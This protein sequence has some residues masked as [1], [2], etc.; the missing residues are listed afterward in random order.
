[1]RAK[2]AEAGRKG[3]RAGTRAKRQLAGMISWGTRTD[4]Q[5]LEIIRRLA[6][7]GAAGGRNKKSV[8]A[9]AAQAARG[10]ATVKKT[11]MSTAQA[12]VL[13]EK[14]MLGGVWAPV[15][16]QQVVAVGRPRVEDY[17][18]TREWLRAVD[19]W[20]REA[21]QKLQGGAGITE[22]GGE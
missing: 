7:C 18:S 16:V 20:D 11:V 21:W 5:R 4:E 10:R 17:E 6:E 8:K 14:G 3:G 22:E 9:R 2:A 19:K 12:Q 15:R 13:H 1:M